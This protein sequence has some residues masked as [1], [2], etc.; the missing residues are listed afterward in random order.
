MQGVGA[1]DEDRSG[2]FERGGW[3]T[4]FFDEETEALI[5]R[6]YERADAF[7]L[8]RRTY[9]I[10]AG[11]WG[12]MEDPGDNP[13]YDALNTRTKYVATSS[14]ADPE[15]AKTT[16]LSGDVTKAVGELKARSGGELQVHGS[17]R[18][19][20]SLLEDDL[21]DELTL[22]TFPVIVGDGTRLFPETGPDRA[23]EFVDSQEPTPTGVTLQT[24]RPVGR[25]RYAGV[26]GAKLGE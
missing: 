20:R 8:G 18:L 12:T 11:S 3:G 15:W 24:Y 13:I 5:G 14:L 23:L 16:V 21:I 4:P 10:F 2:G 26:E 6:I 9:E 1:P 25:P 19:I 17:G 7:L 22:L